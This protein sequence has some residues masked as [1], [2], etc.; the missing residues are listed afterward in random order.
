VRTIGTGRAWRWARRLVRLATLT[1]VG[2]A[3]LCLAG[4][5]V[6]LRTRLFRDL[7][8]ADPGSL[9]VEYASAYS[10]WPGRIHVEGLSIRGLDSNV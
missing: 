8:S 6:F 9:R 7:I 4:M 1:L 2:A 10:L 5:N 3:L